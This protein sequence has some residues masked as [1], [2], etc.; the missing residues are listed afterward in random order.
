MPY[1]APNKCSLIFELRVGCSLRAE[2]GT[3]TSPDSLAETLRQG[4]E[5]EIHADSGR[6]AAEIACSQS[7][8]PARTRA[9]FELVT[10]DICTNDS[11]WQDCLRL[12]ETLICVAREAWQTERF[13]PGCAFRGLTLLL[14]SVYDAKAEKRAKGKKKSTNL[15]DYLRPAG[16]EKRLARACQDM[17]GVNEPRAR[18]MLDAHEILLRY[19]MRHQLI[20]T[21]DAASTEK[22]LARLRRMLAR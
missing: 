3:Q 10:G 5:E 8:C 16:L 7:P 13:A 15:L 22:E 14:N 12:Y 1:A 19:A 18:L 17:I 21:S 2:Q 9:Q 20:S 6:Q 11:A 4:I